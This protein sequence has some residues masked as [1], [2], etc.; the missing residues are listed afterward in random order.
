MWHADRHLLQSHRGVMGLMGKLPSRRKHQMVAT[1]RTELR[2][3]FAVLLASSLS[4]I[5]KPWDD[6][7]IVSVSKSPRPTIRAQ[8][9]LNTTAMSCMRGL[10]MVVG[11]W[12]TV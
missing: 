8:E 2:T 5:A 7:S 11:G 1:P 9:S 6:L 12:Q 10:I 3:T 4:E